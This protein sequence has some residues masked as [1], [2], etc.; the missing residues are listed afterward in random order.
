M[1]WGLRT[2]ALRKKT[3]ERNTGLQWDKP[4]RNATWSWSHPAPHAPVATRVDPHKLSIHATHSPHRANLPLCSST[5]PPCPFMPATTC[6]AFNA[7]SAAI[8]TAAV[9]IDVAVAALIPAVIKL[10][11]AT[12]PPLSTPAPLPSRTTHSLPLPCPSNVP[13]IPLP[14]LEALCL[15]PVSRVPP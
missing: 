3:F 2:T 9:T 14:P 4:S 10:V 11:L 15:P 5:P 1:T 7:V 6:T 13:V 8:H 12:I